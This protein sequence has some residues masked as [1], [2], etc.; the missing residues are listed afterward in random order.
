MQ[1]GKQ[2]RL[3]DELLPILS[4]CVSL[5][6]LGTGNWVWHVSDGNPTAIRI[7]VDTGLPR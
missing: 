6:C 4:Q 5:I 2:S 3:R 1:P 7:A